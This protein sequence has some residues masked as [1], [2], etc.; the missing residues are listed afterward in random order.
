M[1]KLK[2]DFKKYEKQRYP[3]D[4]AEFQNQLGDFV[5]SF[6]GQNPFPNIPDV[7][8]GNT[9][10]APN[11]NSNGL[12]YNNRYYMVTNFRTLLSQLYIEHGIVQT[13]I[14]LPVEDGLKGDIRILSSQLDGDEIEELTSE[15]RK[16]DLFETIMQSFK[17]ARLFGGAGII[18]NILNENPLSDFNID[19]IKKGSKVEFYV[20]DRWELCE[21]PYVIAPNLNNPTG[22]ASDVNFNYYGS[23]IN[24]SRVVKVLGKEAPS[25]QRLQL[26]GWG[27][28]EVERLVAPM[29]KYFKNQNVIFELLDEAKID[30]YSLD[31]Y[32]SSFVAGE[33]DKIRQAIQYSNALKSYLN[34]MILDKEDDFTQKQISFSGMAEILRESYNDLASALRMPVTKLWGMSAEGFNSGEDDIENYNSMIDREVRGKAK[35]II[36]ELCKIMC[37]SLF[38]FAPDDFTVEFPSLRVLKQ[39]EEEQKRSLIYSRFSNMYTEG[40]ITKAEF[41]QILKNRGVINESLEM[42][43]DNEL[44]DVQDGNEGF[45]YN[46]RQDSTKT[47]N[48][49][50]EELLEKKEKIV[51]E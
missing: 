28:S 24:P 7:P 9:G 15:I 12:F 51:R 11:V 23:E 4:S 30:V 45:N 5:S 8:L 50:S 2:R 47:E 32:R 31:G 41:Y 22:I 40:L 18:V 43:N 44:Y 13:L 6:A 21:N 19:K 14:D 46:Y 16:I 35:R 3:K 42:Q 26:A 37:M 48:I 39:L 10:T 25:I 29:N 34:A 49:D 38:G 27:M 33:E 20:A 36:I 17:W 1:R